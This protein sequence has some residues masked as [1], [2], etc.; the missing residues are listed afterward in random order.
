MAGCAADEAEVQEGGF[1]EEGEETADG[2][3]SRF[4]GVVKG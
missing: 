4:F 1:G 3:V 2:E